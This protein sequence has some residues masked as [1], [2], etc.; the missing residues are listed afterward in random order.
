MCWIDKFSG[1]FIDG[2]SDPE[3]A[4]LC[5]GAF[6]TLQ[7]NRL[8]YLASAAVVPLEKE[9]RGRPFNSIR[10]TRRYNVCDAIA[11]RGVENVD[12]TRNNSTTVSA[13]P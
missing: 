9:F 2:P 7:R 8:S 1:N 11:S 6:T 4:F 13:L 5:W 10:A 12:R 3:V